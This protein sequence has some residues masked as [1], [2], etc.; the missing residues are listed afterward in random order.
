MQQP[1]YPPRPPA[2]GFGAPPPGPQWQQPY[3]PQGGYPPGWGAG[4]CP[5][6]NGGPLTKPSFTWWGGLLG[7]KLL[8]HTVCASCGFAFNGKTGKSNNAA[9]AI[10]MGVIFGIVIILFVLRALA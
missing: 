8:N 1:P 4:A 9:I 10:Y 6:C 7:P 3:G 5:R 2:G